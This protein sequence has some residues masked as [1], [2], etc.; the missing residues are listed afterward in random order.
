MTDHTFEPR[1]GRTRGKISVAD[2]ANAALAGGVAIG[3]TCDKVPV[4]TAF[5]IGALAGAISTFGFAALQERFQ[6]AVRKVDTCGVLYLHGLPGLFGGLAAAVAIKGISTSTQLQGTLFTI[7]SAVIFGLIT[8]RIL[9]LFGRRK[10]A[11]TDSEEL[12]LD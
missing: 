7:I 4:G 9:A 2:I 8:G 3:S 1:S 5:I 6:Q 10:E 12:L 11:Y